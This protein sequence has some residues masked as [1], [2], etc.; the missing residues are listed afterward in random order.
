[1]TKDDFSFQPIGYFSCRQR[2]RFET[3]RQGVFADNEGEIILNDDRELVEA[4]DDLRGVERIWIIFVFHLNETWRT[5]VVPPV[6]PGGRRI[7]TFATRSPHRPNRIGMSCVELVDIDGRRI[8][9]RNH[10]LLDATPVLD[11]KPYIPRAD[12][13]PGSRVGWL[14]EAEER[15]FEVVFSDAAAEKAAYLT[16]SGGPDL[17]NFA[18]IQLGSDPC[19]VHRK[20]VV[21]NPDGTWTIAFRTWRMT[22]SVGERRNDVIDLGSGSSREELLDGTHRYDDKELHRRFVERFE[23]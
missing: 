17:V 22:F 2:Y 19:N 16:A 9:V 12:S 4:C 5:H 1:M 18:R 14:E 6:S 10:D 20:R 7:G 11:I 23:R 3:P 13:F 21:E 15:L 8:R